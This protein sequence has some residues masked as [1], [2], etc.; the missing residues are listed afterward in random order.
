MAIFDFT[1]YQLIMIAI[2]ILTVGSSS[3]FF[4]LR[5]IDAASH[6]TE[7]IRDVVN[8]DIIGPTATSKG[9]EF[10]LEIVD[11]SAKVYQYEGWSYMLKKPFLG[12]RGE[13][14]VEVR[15]HGDILIEELVLVKKI[16]SDEVLRR[17]V[18]DVELNSDRLRFALNTADVAEVRELLTGLPELLSPTAR[19]PLPEKAVQHAD[20]EALGPVVANGVARSIVV[21]VQ[22]PNKYLWRLLALPGKRFLKK[23]I[24]RMNRTFLWE[25]HAPRRRTSKFVLRIRHPNNEP[26]V[27][28][29]GPLEIMSSFN[30]WS[31]TTDGSQRLLDLVYMGYGI[32]RD[33]IEE[34][35][36]AKVD[37]NGVRCLQISLA[38]NP[39][40][41]GEKNQSI[42]VTE[43]GTAQMGFRGWQNDLVPSREEVLVPVENVTLDEFV[44]ICSPSE[45]P[46]NTVGE[47]VSD[48]ALFAE[49][50][51]AV[52]GSA[53]RCYYRGQGMDWYIA[54]EWLPD[55]AVKLYDI[56]QVKPDTP[57][58]TKGHIL[59]HRLHLGRKRGYYGDSQQEKAG[60]C[61]LQ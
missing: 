8:G 18:A 53:V 21:D 25:R 46:L 61:I 55:G 23:Q 57:I 12:F 60:Y 51:T 50:I 20:H 37:S 6:R 32:R 58:E 47:P 17:K 39:E 28:E 14:Q 9:N 3:L 10:T 38:R 5:S 15:I 16:G 33:F 26:E 40:L 29:I 49:A 52:N 44:D 2:G 42:S 27:H 13:T 24:G 45:L 19:E 48:T 1:T 7:K 30:P 31:A 4:R 59:W 54:I 11:G 36:Y 22:F 34:D 41:V 35:E 43:L 56:G